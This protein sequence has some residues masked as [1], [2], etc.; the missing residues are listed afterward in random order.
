VLF[1]S[2]IESRKNHLLAFSGWLTL[3]KRFGAR[4]VPKLVCVGNNGWL[5]SAVFEKLAASELLRQRVIMLSRIPDPE[6]A[7]L[8]RNCLFTLYPSSYEGWGLP[9]TESLCYGKVPLLS[10]SSSLPEAGGKF[11][12]FFSVSS[13]SEFVSKLERLIFDDAY[14][15]EREA[16]IR[17]EFKPRAWSEIGGQ[18]V[19]LVRK[20]ARTEA[21]ASDQ[22]AVAATRPLLIKPGKYYG[23][24]ENLETHIWPGMSSG[25]IYRQGDA[26]WWCE[27]WGCW[28]KAKTAKLAF[29]VPIAA[30]SA[31]KLFLGVRGAQGVAS[32][33]TLTIEGIGARQLPIAADAHKWV[34]FTLDEKAIDRL[35]RT[36]DSV[37]VEVSISGDSKAD[38]SIGSGGSDSRIA[39]IGVLGFMACEETDISSRMNLIEAIAVD[40]VASLISRPVLAE[41][42]PME[43][44]LIGTETISAD[45]ASA[46]ENEIERVPSTSSEQR[47]LKR[48]ST[49]A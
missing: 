40:D 17:A 9:V 6:L 11:G 21:V 32:T 4:K 48:R 20:W 24:T 41:F 26:W 33:A 18:I 8:Y 47:S 25:E 34:I 7:A 37:T 39:S 42:T 2:T 10:D 14:R 30:G 35:E 38:F 29:Q 43:D 28:T 13:E 5:N 12:E 46:A 36:G 16:I 19:E 45:V 31:L 49:A 3:I 15:A 27:P 22:R 44:E 1:V 23:L